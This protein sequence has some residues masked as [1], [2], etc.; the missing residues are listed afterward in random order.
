M[1]TRSMTIV[2][3]PYSGDADAFVPL[4]RHC[5]GYPA[6]AGAA[7]CE[8]LAREPQDAEAI[9]CALLALR[10]DQSPYQSHPEPVYRAATWQPEDQGDL[11]HVYKVHRAEGAW[12]VTHYA[13]SRGVP[14]KD[15]EDYRRWPN[16]DY[17]LPEFV[18]LVNRERRLCNARL[19]Q[20]A[21]TSKFY[22][23]A[24]PYAML[25]PR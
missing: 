8:I 21:S 5:D 17:S 24:S 18:D 6:E 12:R 9:V 10:Y 1:S 14:D 20:L 16:A 13:L 7:L 15:R 25:E 3:Q 4:Y 11:E 23:D 22:A 2:E 19:K